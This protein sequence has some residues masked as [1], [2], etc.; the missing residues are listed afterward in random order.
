MT[1]NTYINLPVADLDRTRRFFSALGFT[2]DA[3]SSDETA[4]AMVISESCA[5]MLLTHD[6][7]RQFTPRPVADARAATEVLTCLQLDS[8]EAVDRMVE[9]AL[10]EGG[11]DIREPQDHGFM[12]GRAF[13]DPDGH[14]WEVIWMDPAQM[15]P[16]Q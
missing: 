9:A 14:I 13:Q 12:Y 15:P 16:K 10:A 1:T 2:F 11:A 5:A 8:R 6:K 4:L 3:R 7:F